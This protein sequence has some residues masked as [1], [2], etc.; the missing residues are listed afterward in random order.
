M[1][2]E[3][4]DAE[5]GTGL[6][7]KIAEKMQEVFGKDFDAKKQAKGL[8]ALAAAIVGYIQENAEVSLSGSDP[9]SV[10]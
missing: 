4:G 6:A 10:E 3:A 8:N 2:M 7:G 9:A 5:Q 1:A